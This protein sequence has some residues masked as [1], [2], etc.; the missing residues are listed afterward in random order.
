MRA[1]VLAALV[2]LVAAGCVDTSH[3]CHSPV[4]W[5][6]CAGASAQAGA[7]GTPP[8]IASL[9]LPTCAFLETPSATGT[10]AVDD[11][12]GDAQT[13][14]A[15]FYLGARVNES[16]FQLDDPGRSGGGW[17]GSVVLSVPG[18]MQ[19]MGELTYDV[20]VKVT[21]RAGNQ[22]APVCNTFSLLR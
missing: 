5:K 8:V 2:A 16:E 1:E 7:S 13:V 9:T 20:R 3:R 10:L 12:D 4:A 14:K 22:S 6:R 17:N 15:S 19:A 11:P 18:V 21:D